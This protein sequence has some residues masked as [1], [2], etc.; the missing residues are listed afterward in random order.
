VNDRDWESGTVS[1]FRQS[2]AVGTPF[3][4]RTAHASTTPWYFNWDLYHVVDVFED[5]EVE[6]HAIRGGVAMGDMS[7]LSKCVIS[8]SDAPG[9]VDRLITRDATKLVVRR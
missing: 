2:G 4:S 3:Q 6:L 8:G 9:F 5:S 7:P 1:R